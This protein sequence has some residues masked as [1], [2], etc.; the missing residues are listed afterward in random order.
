MRGARASSHWQR[1]TPTGGM[2]GNSLLI[3]PASPCSPSTR[4]PPDSH[5][6]RRSRPGWAARR[7]SRRAL[8]RVISQRPGPR[9]KRPR[10]ATPHG[11][12]CSRTP[13]TMPP[14]RSRSSLSSW[15]SASSGSAS[16]V[17]PIAPDF[18]PGWKL[19]SPL[20]SR[21]S[22]RRWRRCSRGH[23]WR[24]SPTSSALPP[25]ASR[26]NPRL[27]NGLRTS[28]LARPPEESRRPRWRCRSGGVLWPTGSWS[29]TPPT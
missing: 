20:K 5:G 3:R 16:C 27:R 1:S 14:A 8:A 6:R 19:R 11:G 13:T 9:S 17:P 29:E 10:P 22:S 12:D 15:P 25:R 26:Q 23:W 18:A 28:P 21:A 4:L 2:D 24:R 7:A